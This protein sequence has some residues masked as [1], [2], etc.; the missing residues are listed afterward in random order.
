MSRTKKSLLALL[1]CYLIWGLQPIYWNLL[2]RFNSMFVLC[3]RIVMSMVFTWLFLICTGRLRELLAAFKDRR[4]MRSLVPAAVFI[5]ADW[6]LFNWA[7]MNGHVLDTAL[8]YYM[9][10]MVIFI[11]GLVLFRERGHLL[12]YLA[13][14]VAFVGVLISTVQNGS[15]PLIA[16][17]CSISWPL[18]ATVKKAANADPI[19][20]IAVETTLL[21]PFAIA[22]S[23]LLYGGEGGYGSV[24]AADLALLICS[25]LVTATPMILYTYVVNDL[26]FKVVGILQYT[27]ST[28]SFLCGILFLNEE[29][30]P[31]KLVMFAFIIA[32]LV[33]FTAGSFRKHKEALPDPS[34]TK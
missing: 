18:Y 23:V 15:F 2:G 12:E 6:G 33:I 8:G 9:N 11:I 16:V 25:G 1:L 13:V 21:A 30:T 10:P 31:A 34:A 19:V 24:R 28:I 3:V 5:C 22:A 17:L 27:S 32:G 29:A 14:G 20:S 26:P 7:V 4:L